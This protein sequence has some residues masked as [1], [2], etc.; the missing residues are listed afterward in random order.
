MIKTKYEVVYSFNGKE[1]VIL[2]TDDQ[3]L[4]RKK[5]AEIEM[6]E[7]L[8]IETERLID[9][10]TVKLPEGV[11]LDDLEQTFESLFLAFAA[12]KKGMKRAL[13]GATYYQESDSDGADT[14]SDLD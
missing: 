7:S 3:T 4:A 12:D 5:D 6:A 13:K 11:R 2:E 1:K 10:G 9:N 14:E 8:L